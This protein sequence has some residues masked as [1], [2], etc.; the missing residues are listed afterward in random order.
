MHF[1][2]DELAAMAPREDAERLRAV[3]N[4]LALASGRC[5]SKI[6][7]TCTSAIPFS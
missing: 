3:L 6:F 2:A 4:S 5:P 1:T 7:S